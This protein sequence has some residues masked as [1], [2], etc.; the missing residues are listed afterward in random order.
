[1]SDAPRLLQ[2]FANG[3]LVRPSAAVPNTVV[4]ARALASLSSGSDAALASAPPAGAGP[5]R[6]IA[7]AIGPTDHLIFVMADGLGMNLIDALPQDAFLRQHTR[8][9]MQSVYPSSTAPAL[10]S[11]ATGLWPA[12]HAVTGWFVYL[13]EYG[14]TATVL[15]FIERYAERPLDE[16]GVDP[17][18]VFPVPSDLGHFGGDS[19]CVIPTYIHA[20]VYSRYFAGGAST[21]AYDS[22]G[23]A[24]RSIAQRV[25]Q[26]RQPTFTYL[27]VP[28]IDHAEH[29]HGPHS[30]EVRKT[31]A[32]LERAMTRLHVEI[33]G[34][35]RIVISADHGLVHVPKSQQT[36]LAADDPLLDLLIVPPS[37]EPRV[38][39]FHVVSG[40]KAAFAATFRERFGAD[41]ALLT[42]DEVDEMRLFGPDALSD[43]ARHRLGDFVAFATSP[44]MILHK[45]DAPML[46]C[47]GGLTPDEMR[48]P[49]I[50][51]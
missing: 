44:A 25:R 32:D 13:P 46:G 6:D 15:P 34:R 28:F 39:M 48:I 47:H 42:T 29:E 5:A 50:V 51:A 20:S 49:L 9:E 16:L 23:K 12:Q 38:H 24:C 22:L 35:A 43:E 14:V 1:M 19:L 45:P 37:G 3:T 10:T 30:A 26:A 27:Y 41:F 31:V 11:I 33:E 36:E 7:D 4:L 17:S 18:R 8:M 2:F 21:E 40:K